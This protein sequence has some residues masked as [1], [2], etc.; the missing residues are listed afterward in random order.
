MTTLVQHA[1]PK[2][3]Q[4]Y[5]SRIQTLCKN[6]NIC[7]KCI[8]K[9]LFFA[10]LLPCKPI[11]QRTCFLF[12]MLS[13]SFSFRIKIVTVKE[14]NPADLSTGLCNKRKSQF[15]NIKLT[16]TCRA[17]K[18]PR[19]IGNTILIWCEHNGHGTVGLCDYY[20]ILLQQKNS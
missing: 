13:I 9:K 12:V 8:K 3:P 1:L 10:F 4:L 7:L 20:Q 18:S 6:T 11:C 5:L 14:I 19:Y 17:S 16:P 15:N 2:K